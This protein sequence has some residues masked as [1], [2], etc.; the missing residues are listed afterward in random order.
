MS[1]PKLELKQCVYCGGQA[2]V[3]LRR[4]CTWRVQCDRCYARGEQWYP[5]SDEAAAEWNRWM[6][7]VGEKIEADQ[8]RNGG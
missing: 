5:T 2:R 7:A 1:K 8:E 3:L 4:P 6:G